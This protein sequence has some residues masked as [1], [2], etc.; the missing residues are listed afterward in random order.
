MIKVN[1][2]KNNGY[3][4]IKIRDACMKP[5]GVPRISLVAHNAQ[6]PNGLVL[7]QNLIYR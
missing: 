4:T 3:F 6:G 7:H 2:A 5:E 1:L